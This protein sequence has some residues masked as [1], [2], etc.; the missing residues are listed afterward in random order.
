MAKVTGKLSKNE[1]KIC[2]VFIKENYNDIDLAIN[3]S[4]E[5][6]GRNPVDLKNT[7][8]KESSEL[9]KMVKENFTI[10]VYIK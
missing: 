8:N 2:M 10:G 4:A 3:N 7:Y 1:I 5:F 6:L 9:H